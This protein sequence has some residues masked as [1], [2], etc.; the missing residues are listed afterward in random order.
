MKTHPN[1]LILLKQIKDIPRQLRLEA[2]VR[3][4][5]RD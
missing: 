1:T 4:N 2:N 3:A 5:W